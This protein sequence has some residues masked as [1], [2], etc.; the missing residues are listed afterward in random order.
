MIEPPLLFWLF[1]LGWW[2][3]GV[4]EWWPRLVPPLFGLANLFLVRSLAR[5][6]WPDRPEV[7]KTAPV[8]LL[9]FLLWSV[10]TTLL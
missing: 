9:G 10:F 4:D 6:L 5:R 8:V 3:F 7:A 1:H 2:L